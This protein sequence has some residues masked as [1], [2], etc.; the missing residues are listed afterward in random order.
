M[1]NFGCDRLDVDAEEY[2]CNFCSETVIER[3]SEVSRATS[4]FFAFTYF[5]FILNNNKQQL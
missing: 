4:T 3:L 1:Q 5:T 2:S